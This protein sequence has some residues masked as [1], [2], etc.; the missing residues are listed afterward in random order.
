MG[1]PYGEVFDAF[2]EFCDDWTETY[3]ADNL[4]PINVDESEDIQNSIFADADKAQIWGYP[5]DR[6]PAT[7]F[8]DYG[9]EEQPFGLACVLRED[10]PPHRGNARGTGGSFEDYNYEHIQQNYYRFIERKSSENE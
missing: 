10:T 5:T 2:S 9:D 1:R 8:F 6:R 3:Q 7:V 4:A